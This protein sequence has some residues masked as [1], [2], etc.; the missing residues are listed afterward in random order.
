MRRMAVAVIPAAGTGSRLGDTIEGSKEVADLGGRPLILHLIDRLA[1]AGIERSVVVTR[2]EKT[3]LLAVLDTVDGVDLRTLEASPSELHSVAAAVAGIEE[4]VVLAYPDVLFEPKDA[5]AAV[6]RRQDRTHADVVLGL[7]PSDDPE[8]VDMVEL[9]AAGRPVQIVIKQPA[10]GLRS[11]WAI[12]GWSPRFSGFLIDFASDDRARS[13]E[14]SV[15]DVVQAALDAGMPVEAVTFD[16]GSYLDV[17]TPE[18]LAE[19]RLGHRMD[20]W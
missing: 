20:G 18:R 12:A 16:D 10:R 4:P 1:L 9:D 2:P 11:S 8:S 5:L 3:D 13:V 7:F 17:G 15:G 19:A 14:P 6:A